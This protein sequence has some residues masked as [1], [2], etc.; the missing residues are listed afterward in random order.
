MP[1]L[2]QPLSFRLMI[3]ASS[4]APMVAFHFAGE[5]GANDEAD[6]NKRLHQALGYR[7]PR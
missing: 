3:A 7:A 5:R 1:S 4:V 2:S 6:N